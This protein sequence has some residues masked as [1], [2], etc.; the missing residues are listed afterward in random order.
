MSFDSRRHQQERREGLPLA[1][2]GRRYRLGP[3]DI[4]SPSS[5][6]HD[7]GR[8]PSFLSPMGQPRHPPGLMTDRCSLPLLGADLNLRTQGAFGG[9]GVGSTMP[10]GSAQQASPMGSEADYVPAQ[11]EQLRQQILLRSG[12]RDGALT[13]TGTS[14][15]W[16]MASGEQTRREL[17]QHHQQCQQ[18][19]QQQGQQYQE[20]QYQQHHARSVRRETSDSSSSSSSTPAQ[21]K[22]DYKTRQQQSFEEWKYNQ[23]LYKRA[24][25][26]QISV[27][28]LQRIE[29]QRQ[30][31]R[32]QENKRLQKALDY[33]AKM[34]ARRTG[35]AKAET[36]T[37]NRSREKGKQRAESEAKTL[38]HDFLYFH[39]C[40]PP[41]SPSL[42]PSTDRQD[43]HLP[44]SPHSDSF[45]CWST[46]RCRELLAQHQQESQERKDDP[47]IQSLSY[48]EQMSSPLMQSN[49]MHKL[50]LQS[51]R[52]FMAQ[53][54]QRNAN[55]PG[56][57]RERGQQQEAP[58]QLPK[59]VP[60]RS[61]PT[62]AM[63]AA[64]GGNQH[65][66]F[67]M[68]NLEWRKYKTNREQ[69][70]RPRLNRSPLC[71]EQWDLYLAR[72][73]HHQRWEQQ[74]AAH[75]PTETRAEATPDIE[76]KGHRQQRVT[77]RESLDL[78]FY[79]RLERIF[80]FQSQDLKKNAETA[81]KKKKRREL[82]GRCRRNSKFLLSCVI[83][84]EKQRLEENAKTEADRLRRRLKKY[85]EAVFNDLRQR[86]EILV[87]K[88]QKKYQ[89]KYHQATE[90]HTSRMEPRLLREDLRT[91]LIDGID[92]SDAEW[93]GLWVN[94]RFEA[95]RL[96]T[97][98]VLS[99]FQKSAFDNGR[100]SRQRAAWVVDWLERI[101]STDVDCYEVEFEDGAIEEFRVLC[102]EHNRRATALLGR[103]IWPL[104]EVLPPIPT[105]LHSPKEGF[106]NKRR[107]KARK[108]EQKC[109]EGEK[110]Q[111]E[112]C[113]I[114]DDAA[115]DDT[116]SLQ[117]VSES[118]STTEDRS[119]TAELDEREG[120]DVGGP[121]EIVNAEDADDEWDPS[122]FD[123]D[124][125]ISS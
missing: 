11:M 25:S 49:E 42:H 65:Q 38:E 79:G 71:K 87:K 93:Y 89:K 97:E 81:E 16:F 67:E 75:V 125:F 53:K 32:C 102:L 61:V 99:V 50:A 47:W 74:E 90:K 2:E 4:A 120:D 68:S 29:Q 64:D 72:E 21:Y 56:M 3:E 13:D 104:G 69:E 103:Q 115:V 113:T 95:H 105:I 66:E 20:Q 118:C 15:I 101:D 41:L 46:D 17:Q 82:H 100:R 9:P 91:D 40:S 37:Q 12:N 23:Q 10:V 86:K 114:A 57:D 122:A 34:T 70:R 123:D 18:D 121:L 33:D 96:Q 84:W 55:P 76:A 62:R 78:V 111:K 30:R 92:N 51:H 43:N 107:E 7:L 110:Q 39:P 44:Q 116:P 48:G 124:N 27:P 117:Y 88:Y 119:E 77:Q 36:Q 94:H 85:H 58:G 22:R 60:T 6:F 63:N 5:V 35:F 45:V 73:R 1:S 52:A 14:G 83:K 106:I 28:E 24:Q 80:V 98:D 109:E 19:Q 59:R 54:F 31:E 8:H 108:A 112:V 26:L